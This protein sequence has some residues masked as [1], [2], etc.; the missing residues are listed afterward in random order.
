[1]YPL[2]WEYKDIVEQYG[3][4]R[5]VHRYSR[6]ERFKKVLYQICCLRGNVEEEV[7]REIRLIP[8]DARTVWEDIRA[9]LKKSRVRKYDLIPLIIFECWGLRVLES[10]EMFIIDEILDDFKRMNFNFERGEGRVYFPNIRFVVLR[11]LEIK[12][13]E[14]KYLVPMIRTR[15]KFE[16]LD[17]LFNKFY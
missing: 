13:V 9:W 10:D 16:I 2:E 4:L 6:F 5:P 12:G 11:Y 15:K 7:L 3:N 14:F 17:G 8:F 1:M